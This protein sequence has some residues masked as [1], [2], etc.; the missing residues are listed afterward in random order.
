MICTVCW[1]RALA[2]PPS[3]NAIAATSAPPA[4]QPRSRKKR[5]IPIPPMNREP[6][7]TASKARRL[8][9]GVTAANAT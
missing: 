3:A 4:C 9:A 2:D 8:I 6:K 5:M 1:M 7:V